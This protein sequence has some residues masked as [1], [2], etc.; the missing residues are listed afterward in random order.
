MDRT[1]TGTIAPGESGPGS[2]ADKRIL[3]TPKIS[4]T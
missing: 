1:L 4:R 3:Y 2:N